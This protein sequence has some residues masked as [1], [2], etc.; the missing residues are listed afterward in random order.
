[1]VPLNGNT[2]PI[3]SQLWELGGRFDP[4]AKV[5]LVPAV[6][7]AEA[8]KL[9]KPES[10]KFMK[11]SGGAGATL[12]KPSEPDMSTIDALIRAQFVVLQDAVIYAHRWNEGA[13]MRIRELLKKIE[14]QGGSA[15]YVERT[16]K[17]FRTRLSELT[18]GR[19]SHS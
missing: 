19:E 1:M 4:K 9:L 3:R 5:W 15:S 11:P 16:I 17:S 8:R 12:P 2:Y 6:R 10:S 13:E 7:I 14:S 18:R